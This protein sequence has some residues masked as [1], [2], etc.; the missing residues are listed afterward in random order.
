MGVPKKWLVYRE[1]P[2]K[3]DDWRVPLFMETPIYSHY[4][5][6]CWKRT[7]PQYVSIQIILGEVAASVLYDI[8]RVWEIPPMLV[9]DEAH[10][11]AVVLSINQLTLW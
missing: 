1:K 6:Q 11:K 4:L 9:A 2:I 7:P 3:I 5:R 8:H 10:E